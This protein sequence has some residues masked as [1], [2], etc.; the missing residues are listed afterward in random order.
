MF[1]LDYDYTAGNDHVSVDSLKKYF[2]SGVKIENYNIEIDGWTFYGQLINDSIKQYDDDRTISSRL[3]VYDDYT[4]GCLLDFAHF[5]K[6]YRLIVA[7]WS[8][9]KAWD[10][11]SRVIQQT[12]FTGKIKAPVAN[13]RI[14]IYY[15]LEQ[16]KE[17]TLELSKG[18]T[19][20]L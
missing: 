1:V 3:V 15:I 16:S 6:N 10:S 8:K 19:K 7:D 4:A 13:T 18:A 17:T 14:I 5:E 20:V 12:I 9:Q 2:L 11:D